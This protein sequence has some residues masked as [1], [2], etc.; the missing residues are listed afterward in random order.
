M[1]D[2]RVRGYEETKAIEMFPGVV[3]RTL[4]SGDRQ[5]LVRI[6]LSAGAEVPEH[7]HPHEQA[8]T[9]ASGQISIRIGDETRDV[10]AGGAYLIPGDVPHFV[11]ALE[12][13]T[14]VEVFAPVREE[15]AGD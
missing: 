9:V 10:G 14:L 2:P 5:T 6:E 11:R 1:A 4:V 13:S 7:T 3:R 12:P 15:F 8:G